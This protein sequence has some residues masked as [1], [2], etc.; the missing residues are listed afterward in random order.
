MP[1]KEA[2]E[3]LLKIAD[4]IEKGAAEVTE[5]VC[6]S[7]NHTATLAKINTKRREAA[8]QTENVTVADVTVN[9]SIHCPAC[10]DGVMTYR[11][12]EASADF[13]FDPSKEAKKADDDKDKDEENGEEEKK[14]SEPIDYDSLQRYQ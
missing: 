14:A 12:T 6:S 13:Y 4:E 7:C 1:L 2:A 11:P 3:Q 9:D 8:E 5:F 10:D